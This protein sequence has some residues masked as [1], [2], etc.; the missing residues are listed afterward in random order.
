[1][2]GKALYPCATTKGAAFQ[3]NFSDKVW[4]APKDFRVRALGDASSADVVFSAP[5][6]LEKSEVVFPVS[7]DAKAVVDQLVE[8][9][10]S[11]FPM[12]DAFVCRRAEKSGTA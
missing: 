12:T 10:P 4:A 5:V 3:A 11:V 9:D 2:A 1:M 7:L 8:K 6:S